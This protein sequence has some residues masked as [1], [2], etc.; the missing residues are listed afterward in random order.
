[1]IIYIFIRWDGVILGFG[2]EL[3]ESDL[4]RISDNVVMVM[5]RILVLV[6]VNIVS[7]VF[8]FISYSFDVSVVIGFVFDLFNMWLVIGIGYGIIY[9]GMCMFICVI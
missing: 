3:F 6:D 2:K 7:V 8:G 9:V 1:M 4:D 5:E